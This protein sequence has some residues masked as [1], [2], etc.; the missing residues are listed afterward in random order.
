MLFISEVK[1]CLSYSLRFVSD[2]ND[3]EDTDLK[4]G[5]NLVGHKPEDLEHSDVPPVS[6]DYKGKSNEA[7][8]NDGVEGEDKSGKSVD[9]EIKD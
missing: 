7:D 5:E 3:E 9:G 6:V 1:C 4:S 2:G 8:S